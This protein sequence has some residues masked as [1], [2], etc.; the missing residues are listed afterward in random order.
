MARSRTARTFRA[1]LFFASVSLS[2]VSAFAEDGAMKSNH[3]CQSILNRKKEA[4]T[5][6][7]PGILK[8]N[9]VARH[10][11]E[12]ATIEFFV[13]HVHACHKGL[14]YLNE[15][16]DYKKCFAAVISKETR[17]TFPDAVKEYAG[18]RVLVKGKIEIYG[19]TPK[20]ILDNP[21]QIT[22]V[23]I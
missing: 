7:C 18:K 3:T 10:V 8:T 23:K 6:N 4:P 22:I 2:I 5:K 21:N 13:D 12:L 17:A 16:H 14:V 9:E 20:V 19:G 15:S 11:G 1:L